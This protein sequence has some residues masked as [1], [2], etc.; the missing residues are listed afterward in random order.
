MSFF[1]L[2]H[3]VYV[4]VYIFIKLHNPPPPPKKLLEEILL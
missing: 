2:A 1:F 3:P 4:F